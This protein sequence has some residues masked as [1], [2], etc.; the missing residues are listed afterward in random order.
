MG[1]RQQGGL[2][3]CV[4]LGCLAGCGSSDPPAPA[5]SGASDQ[6]ASD[7]HLQGTYAPTSEGEIAGMTFQ[8][9]TYALMLQGCAS[10]SC[11]DVGTYLVSEDRTTLSLTSSKTGQVRTLPLRLLA[12]KAE[13]SNSAD[14]H[15]Q[16][17]LVGNPYGLGGGSQSLYGGL[18]TPVVL[19]PNTLLP[20]TVTTA[21]VNNQL[22]GLANTLIGGLGEVA[23]IAAASANTNAN[24][25]GPQSASQGSGTD[26]APAT[27][28]AID[29]SKTLDASS[30][31]QSYV[32]A[33]IRTCTAAACN[34]TG[35]DQTTCQQQVCNATDKMTGSADFAAA[36]YVAC[37]MNG[38]QV[39]SN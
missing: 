22:L 5:A 15:P 33:Y 12:T 36:E 2:L 11:V 29:C 10:A 7:A 13:D 35:A 8:D 39:A 4:L 38:T 37:H 6:V 21:S 17:S 20:G 18:P 27:T 16:V 24:A 1:T 26:P 28:E 19:T 3:G 23:G 32:Y 9:Q 31:D 34:A 14:L 25:N 30:S